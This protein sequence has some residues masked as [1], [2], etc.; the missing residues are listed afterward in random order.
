MPTPPPHLPPLDDQ[1][2]PPTAERRDFL[3]QLSTLAALSLVQPVQA[4]QNIEASPVPTPLLAD[5][6][7]ARLVPVTLRINGQTVQRTIDTRTTVLDLLREQLGLTGTKKGCNQ[8]ACGA[9]TVHVNGQNVNSCLALAVM[10]QHQDITTIEGLGS[11]EQLHPMQVAFIAHD[12]FQC[13]Y[14]TSGQIMSA[15][16]VVRD[17][18]ARTETEIRELMSGNIC[19]CGAY[20]GIVAAM[21]SVAAGGKG[22]TQ[23][24]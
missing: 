13:G 4:M 17:G 11:P 16:A 15:V 5:D 10:H 7:A 8:G 6:S 9:C 20:N 12:G 21:Q 18:H 23:R 1:P 14:C 2:V 19:R 3:K 22:L 24:R